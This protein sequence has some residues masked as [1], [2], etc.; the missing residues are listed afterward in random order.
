MILLKQQVK[1]I[2]IICI[3]FGLFINFSCK[4]QGKLV[5]YNNIKIYYKKPI[6]RNK[7][8]DLIKYLKKIKLIKIDNEINMQLLKIRNVVILKMFVTENSLKSPSTEETFK[9][10]RKKI[11]KHLF[12]NQ[13]FEL[14]MSNSTFETLKIFSNTL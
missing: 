6:T 9:K 1:Y 12:K 4:K 13:E 14:H 3:T 11:V 8:Q 5:Q 2:S 10:L 7:V